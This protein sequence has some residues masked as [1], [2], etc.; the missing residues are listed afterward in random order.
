M[1]YICVVSAMFLVP[2]ALAQPSEEAPGEH[3]K[4]SVEPI[5]CE[6]L[7]VRAI[8]TEHAALDHSKRKKY[9]IEHLDIWIRGECNY[10]KTRTDGDE[11]EESVYRVVEIRSAVQVSISDCLTQCLIPLV[12]RGCNG[13]SSHSS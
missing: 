3:A 10:E 6:Y 2:T 1:I 8:V 5:T 12:K 13:D 9:G 7:L 11:D 4:E